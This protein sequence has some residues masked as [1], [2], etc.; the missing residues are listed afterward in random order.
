MNEA[1]W[2]R[3]CGSLLGHIDDYYC[4]FTKTDY[5]IELNMSRGDVVKELQLC[6]SID[7]LSPQLKKVAEQFK[8]EFYK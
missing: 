8:A 2:S 7:E 3:F 5:D 4:R 6:S 1:E